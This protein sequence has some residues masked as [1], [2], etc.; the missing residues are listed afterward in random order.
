MAISASDPGACCADLITAN[1]FN[2]AGAAST[3]GFGRLDR[4]KVA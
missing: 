1:R 4:P 2:E 3:S